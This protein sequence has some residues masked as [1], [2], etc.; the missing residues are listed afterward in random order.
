M[1]VER[2]VIYAPRLECNEGHAE[3]CPPAKHFVLAAG[4]DEFIIYN[5]NGEVESFD[6]DRF[7]IALLSVCKEQQIRIDD[8]EAR[9]VAL[10]SH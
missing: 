4:A 7:C 9:L 10:E 3:P 6:Y 1:R 5:K 2:E 8:L